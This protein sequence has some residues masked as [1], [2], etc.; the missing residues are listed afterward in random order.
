MSKH[1]IN[2]DS[3]SLERNYTASPDRTYAAWSDP[4]IKAN[5]FPKADEFEFRIGGREIVRGSEPG[6]PIYTS[7]AIYQE[8]V[9]DTRIVYTITID[10]GE[11]RISVSVVTVEFNSE[12]SGTKL[13]YT[14]QCAFLDGLDSLEDHMHGANA[15]LDELDKELNRAN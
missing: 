6:G 9:P 2:H 8:I 11:T 12:G 5:W 14:E 13:V 1:F 7:V 4:A 10:K 3:F 15:F